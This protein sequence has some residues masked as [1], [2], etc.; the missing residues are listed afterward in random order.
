MQS[1]KI[2]KRTPPFDPAKPC[3]CGLHGKSYGDCCRNKGVNALGNE[4]LRGNVPRMV[5][6]ALAQVQSSVVQ[7]DSRF[8]IVWNELWHSPQDQTFHQFLDGLAVKTL[9]REWFEEQLRLPPKNQNAIVKWR[10]AMLELLRRPGD[11]D[12]GV[13]TRHILT[14]PAKAYQCFGYDLYWLQLAHK[15]RFP[16]GP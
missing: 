1:A 3:P 9:T 4:M 8:R 10:T 16:P 6:G 5:P 12:D 15:L 13:S 14:G 11:A 2:G 7:G